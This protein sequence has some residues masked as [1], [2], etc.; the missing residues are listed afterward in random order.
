MY[1]KYLAECIG[2]FA[3]VFCGTGAI[4][5]DEVMHGAVTHVGIACT[6]GF[7]VMAMIYVFGPVSGAHFNPAVTLAF[8]ADRKFPW[9]SVVPY[10]LFQ[11]VGAFAGSLVLHGLF[12]GSKFLGATLPAGSDA[13]SI[14]LEGILSFFLMLVI[15]RV[16]KGPKE[17]GLMA[18]LAIG[19]VVLLE[20]MFAGPVCGAS[21]N[22][23]RSIAPAVVG[24]HLSS[25]WVYVA[26]PVS[27]MLFAVCVA[28]IF[29]RPEHRPDQIA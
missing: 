26:G 1:K 15:L 5:I 12:P 13:Q 22:P 6:F 23:A 17:E 18:G 4:T 8:A 3:L 27:G 14:I 28:R 10:I 20:A 29:D 11:L 24:G 19:S 7:V 2:T 16:S 25:M 21:M 9:K